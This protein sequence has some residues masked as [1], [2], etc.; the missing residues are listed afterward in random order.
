MCP[1][2]ALVALDVQVQVHNN[3]LAQAAMASTSRTQVLI[4]SGDMFGLLGPGGRGGW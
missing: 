3:T 4:L 1:S 2:T